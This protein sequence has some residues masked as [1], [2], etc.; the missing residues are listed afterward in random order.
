MKRPTSPENG[1]TFQ[2]SSRTG[3]DNFCA[4]QEIIVVGRSLFFKP[5]PFDGEPPAPSVFRDEEADSPGEDRPEAKGCYGKKVMAE[6][7]KMI[8]SILG[9][10]FIFFIFTLT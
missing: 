4:Q 8:H 2:S 1:E 9:G 3:P 5:V 6:G 10:G 7:K